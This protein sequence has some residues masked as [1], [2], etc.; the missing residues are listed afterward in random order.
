MITMTE[1]GSLKVPRWRRWATKAGE[2]NKVDVPA[3]VQAA[4]SANKEHAQRAL[5]TIVDPLETDDDEP[6][7]V[8]GSVPPSF[9]EWRLK[10][11][12][13]AWFADLAPTDRR[14]AAV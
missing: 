9:G 5:D 4:G 14:D 1:T 3:M 13:K 2:V 12:K 7:Q 10:G 11:M 6:V 8:D